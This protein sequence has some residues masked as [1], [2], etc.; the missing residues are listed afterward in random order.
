M[1][2]EITVGK[3][4]ISTYVSVLSSV[5]VPESD[6]VSLIPVESVFPFD[7][8]AEL[9]WLLF[10]PFLA[11]LSAVF[12]DLCFLRFPPLEPVPLEAPLTRAPSFAESG[13][14]VVDSRS[15]SSMESAILPLKLFLGFDF[16]S[17]GR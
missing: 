16:I 12:L 5:C 1:P 14:V 8:S 10:D 4:E 6:D 2:K 9:L 3:P 17:L 11:L 13:E 15:S 7:D